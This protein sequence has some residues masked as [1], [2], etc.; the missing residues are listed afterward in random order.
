MEKMTYFR[1]RFFANTDDSC[2]TNHPPGNRFFFMVT[3]DY[4]YPPADRSLDGYQMENDDDM[5]FLG[6]QQVSPPSK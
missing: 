2:N 6:T 5:Q 3:F 4:K 1:T